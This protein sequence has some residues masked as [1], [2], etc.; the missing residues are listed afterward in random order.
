MEQYEA[1]KKRIKEMSEIVIKAS[2]RLELGWKSG[3]CWLRNKNG[4][5]A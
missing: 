3:D 1:G 4:W 2:G 5:M